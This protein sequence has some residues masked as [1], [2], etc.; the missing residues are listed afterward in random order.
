[1]RI[2]LIFRTM[3]EIDQ[4][5]AAVFAWP[6][7][8]NPNS[9]FN[10]PQVF[11][12]LAGF[13]DEDVDDIYAPEMGDYPRIDIRGCLDADYS[14]SLAWF[15][16]NDVGN[17]QPHPSGLLPLKMEIQTQVFNFK[18]PSAGDL[19]NNTIL[20][21]YKFIYQG[22]VPLDSFYL[23]LYNDFSIG[24]PDDDFI[25]SD[26]GLNLMYGYNS[27]E[28]DENGFG[29]EIPVMAMSVVHGPIDTSGNEMNLHYL[30]VL[31]SADYLQSDE[32][33]NVLRGKKPNGTPTPENGWMYG[34]NP[35]HPDEVSEIST[36]SLAGHRVGVSA[37]GPFSIKP[38]AVNVVF[39][40]YYYVHEPGNTP[41]QNVQ[42][43]Y[44]QT[45]ALRHHFD[46]GCFAGIEEANSEIMHKAPDLLLYPN[47]TTDE[48]TVESKGN[49][50]NQIEITDLLGRPVQQINLDQNTRKHTIT[51]S[52]WPAGLY[53]VRAGGQV[54]TLVVSK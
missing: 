44:D 47:P 17:G 2:W 23:G 9:G 30:T 42:R 26:P 49:T 24:N 10:L 34:G 36:G 37:F 4:P 15:V 21:G 27:D 18:A 54:K 22:S 31:D 41:L 28:N 33:Y 1:M 51:T 39:A 52:G 53:A 6:G 16:N 5:N 11:H 43:L 35:N 20:V 48:F 40:A 50:F 38:G 12:G 45:S 7:N 8:G 13:Y 3:V 29:T 46:T 14:S 32:F 19:L 25:G